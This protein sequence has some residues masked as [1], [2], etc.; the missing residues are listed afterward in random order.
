MHVYAKKKPKSA[1][2]KQQFLKS[3]LLAEKQSERITSVRTERD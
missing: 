3:L 1:S 2:E